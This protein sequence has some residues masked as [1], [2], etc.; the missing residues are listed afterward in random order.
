MTYPPAPPLAPPS[1][2]WTP[3]PGLGGPPLQ[4]PSTP[5]NPERRRGGRG[6]VAW[7]VVA[8]V[9]A[10]LSGLA[11]AVVGSTLMDRR[12]AAAR[13]AGAVDPAIEMPS[14]SIPSPPSV[15]AAPQRPDTEASSSPLDADAVAAKVVPGLVYIDTLMGYQGAAGA[16]TGMVI[17]PSG[18]V[19]TNNHVIE[20]STKIRVTLVSNGETY[21]A[22][23]IGTSPSEDVALL[24]LDGASNLETV[25]TAALDTVEV[26][27]PVLALGNAGGR[28]GDP[29][30]VTGVVTALDE[31]ITAS[32]FNGGNVER[33][34][35]L[36]RTNA[37]ILPGD[38]GGALADAEGRVI[39]MNTAA[40]A[41]N[42]FG[43]ARSVGYAVSMDRALSIV[44]QIREG[45]ESASVRIGPP[46]FLGVSVTAGGGTGALVAGV[47]DGS[48]AAS[49]GLE[50]GDVITSI[51]GRTVTG[52]Q[53]L[54][55]AVQANEPGT[56][57]QVT[58]TDGS[59]Q[60]RQ[61]TVELATSP[62]N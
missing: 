57:V 19:L 61:G 35:G 33:L 13:D 52:P 9:L 29:H 14:R 34:T 10:L 17:D 30:V 48:P 47:A 41:T 4:P 54:S 50:A 7:V 12:D 58:W 43:S 2:H 1:E 23:V 25:Q 8:V 55:E 11:G 36:I 51:D 15:P 21:D 42:R 28:G 20:G 44:R 18:L 27:E 38:S 16:G 59:G 37:P 53:S 32:D 40:A 22:S 39:G 56:R 49:L 60:K 62:A 5:P 6:V 24:R 45:R 46:A 31:T 3:P 26:G